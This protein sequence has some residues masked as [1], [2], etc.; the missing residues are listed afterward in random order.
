M[1]RLFKTKKTFIITL[2]LMVAVVGSVT[3]LAI[4]TSASG[5]VINSFSPGGIDTV[6]EETNDPDPIT[7]AGYNEKIPTVKNNGPSDAFIRARITVTPS[8]AGVVLYQGSWDENQTN[9]TKTGILYED[10]TFKNLGNENSANWI[11]NSEDG[12]YYYT[13]PIAAGES[14]TSIFDAFTLSSNADVTVYQESVASKTIKA[15]TVTALDTIVEMFDAV[16][17]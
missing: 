5:S 7:T 13:A 8:T 16:D 4:L 9:F 2:V 1:K 14:T 3:T 12:Y 11:Y 6:I 10:G 15:G 17:D